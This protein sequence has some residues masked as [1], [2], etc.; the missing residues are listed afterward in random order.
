VRRLLRDEAYEG[1][2]DAIILGELAP[3]SVLREADLAE[4]LGV[5][6]APVREALARLVGE[7]LVE[8]KAQSYT[9]VSALD[10]DEVRGALFV[11][12]L[13]QVAA[14]RDA[15]L[16]AEGLARMR[17]ANDRFA[18]AVAAGDVLAAMDA[19]DALHGELVAACGNVPLAE[20][21]ERW[22]PLVRR[23]EVRHFAGAHGPESVERH[24]VLI[25]ACAAGDYQAAAQLTDV[26]FAG[27]AE[28]LSAIAR[29][30]RLSSTA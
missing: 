26:I 5:S 10:V 20:T 28:H 22:T 4:R 23:L 25:E 21:I 11:V 27:L 24:D 17:A 6:K 18:Q 8:R 1:I 16:D 3:G 14:A 19:D 2:R 12:R 29:A 15:V 13:L 7:G 30:D 9:R